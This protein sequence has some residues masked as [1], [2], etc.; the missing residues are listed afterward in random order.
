MKR[1]LRSKKTLM[2]GATFFIALSMMM[3]AG[4]MLV[5]QYFNADQTGDIITPGTTEP[6]ALSLWEDGQPYYNYI[7]E[8]L[9]LDIPFKYS[10][11]LNN[12]NKTVRYI[13]KNE[14]THTY[15]Y[16]INISEDWFEDPSSPYYGWTF[17]V[18]NDAGTQSV[19]GVP[20]T[21]SPGT[22]SVFRIWYKADPYYST[23]PD[24]TSPVNINIDSWLIN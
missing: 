6:I 11:V 23:P 19:A 17:G 5:M 15:Q 14:N 2:L 1:M 18:T 22:N 12:E 24:G 7:G 3:S 21:V 8:M 20:L 10:T 16:M 4:A 9:D 13:V